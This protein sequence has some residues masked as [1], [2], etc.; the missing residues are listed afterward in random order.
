MKKPWPCLKCKFLSPLKESTDTYDCIRPMN[1]SVLTIIERWEIKNIHPM[2][3]TLGTS[4]V[5][6]GQG[7]PLTPECPVMESKE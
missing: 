6:S 2:W 5:L 3:R 1:E 7:N 4:F